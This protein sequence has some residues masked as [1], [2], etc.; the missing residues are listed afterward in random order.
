MTGTQRHAFYPR[1][2]RQRCSLRCVMPLYNVHPLFSI[3]V[4]SP[5]LL[6]GTYKGVSLWPHT[7]HN[8]RLRA[9]TEKISKNRKYPSNIL[10]D[11]PRRVTGNA[12]HEYK[13][14]AWFETSRV[15]R[16]TVTTHVIGGELIAIICIGHNSRL[17]VTTEIFEKNQEKP[18]NTLPNSG[19]KP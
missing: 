8:F 16:Q 17:R 13:P 15:P 10:P 2:G 9:T 18:S 11:S 3:C 7:G 12:A 14:L 1:R 5:M 4:I 19:M 6:H